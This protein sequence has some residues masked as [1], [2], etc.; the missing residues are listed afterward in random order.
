[1]RQ[2]EGDV[3]VRLKKLRIAE[4]YLAAACA[5]GNTAALTTFETQY[6][7]TAIRHARRIDG[8]STFLDDVAQ[9][10]RSDLFFCESGAGKIAAYTGR[11][12]LAAWLRVV[13]LRCALNVRRDRMKRL[14]SEEDSGAVVDIRASGVDPELDFLKV[15]CA[16]QFREIFIRVLQRLPPDKRNILRL[17]HLDGLTLTETAA[18]CRVSR[19]TVV[20]WLADT[21]EELARETRRLLHDEL[22]LGRSEIESFLRAVESQ[23]NFTLRPY[24]EGC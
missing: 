19:A 22:R 5:Q 12:S 23:W 6:L 7:A 3:A 20:R 10:V 16:T 2:L 18:V 9:S 21:R 15:R 17:H 8:S 24:L 4:L 14:R 13:V 11:G 1:V